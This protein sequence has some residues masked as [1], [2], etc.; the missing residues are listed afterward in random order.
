MACYPRVLL[1]GSASSLIGL[2]QYFFGGIIT[3]LVG[4]KGE[5]SAEP[6]MVLLIVVSVILIG[7][8]IINYRVF[9]KEAKEQ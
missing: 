8:H 2:L 5:Y 9:K 6:Y 3:P 7:L 4:L 1:Y